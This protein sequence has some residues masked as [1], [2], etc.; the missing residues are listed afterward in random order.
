MNLILPGFL[1]MLITQI[2]KIIAKKFGI[3]W[4]R[5]IVHTFLFAISL[6]Y[7]LLKYYGY[8]ETF[9]TAF[10]GIWV[11]ASG[12]YEILKTILR[13]VTERGIQFFLQ[14]GKY[15]EKIH[16]LQRGGRLVVFFL[17]LLWINIF[18]PFFLQKLY[19]K[20]SNVI[21]FPQEG[22]LIIVGG[23][24]VLAINPVNIERPF[25]KIEA[26]ITAYQ[27]IWQQTDNTPLIMA[28]GK[29]VYR[30]AIACPIWLEFGTMVEIDGRVYICE[31]RMNRKYPNRFDILMFSY[32]DAKNWGIQTK[33][34]KI[35]EKDLPQITRY[36][37]S[38]LQNKISP[39]LFWTKIL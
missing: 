19:L 25:Y 33:T 7:G 24:S 14:K 27:P 38:Y 8:W 4:T 39:S 37:L 30:G 3:E 32:E 26:E 9:F 20:Q 18:F 28:S 29:K 22:K 36:N 21:S 5:I 16:I 15:M 23:N 13:P 34:I 31:D 35:Y 17:I 11:T 1:L 6:I 10:V 2:I 12:T